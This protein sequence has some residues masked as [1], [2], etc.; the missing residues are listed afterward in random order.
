[1]STASERHRGDLRW[2]ATRGRPS[3][4][5]RTSHFQWAGIL[6]HAVSKAGPWSA[7]APPLVRVA[8]DA[9]RARSGAVVLG[10]TVAA[11]AIC[12][13][14]PPLLSFLNAGRW[15]AKV[16]GPA[17]DATVPFLFPERSRARNA[18]RMHPNGAAPNA[19]ARNAA[20]PK[21]SSQ[22]EGL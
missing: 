7:A 17:T 5:S 3:D 20:A 19:A 4:L 21:R 22:G 10:E 8:A 6:S 1:M 16:A 13:S 15:P 2:V 12:R 11:G 18:G 14:P 9:V